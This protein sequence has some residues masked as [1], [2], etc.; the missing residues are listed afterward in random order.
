MSRRHT[1]SPRPR[2][3]HRQRGK[4]QRERRPKNP[5]GGGAWLGL[6]CILIVVGA[7]GTG[8]KPSNADLPSPAL[9]A[10]RSV[11]ASD[12]ALEAADTA[13]P[14]ADWQEEAP[15]GDAATTPRATDDDAD[16]GEVSDPSYADDV[17][18]GEYYEA[19]SGDCV[20]RPVARPSA[21]EGATAQC[22]DGT[23]SF[24][25]SRRGTCSHHGGVSDW[26]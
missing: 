5:N 18:E 12:S 11:A 24:S 13:P 10:E 8:P 15:E 2:H 25:Q 26:L 23:F 16:G 20:H 21:P 7:W 9:V 22:S 6:V 1:R 3:Y 19:A 17:C 4:L 14:S